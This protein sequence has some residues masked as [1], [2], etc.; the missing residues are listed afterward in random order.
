MKRVYG[1]RRDTMEAR[2]AL[3]R[4]YRA[5]RFRC[6]QFPAA[7]DL[8]IPSNPAF[9]P[10]DQ[11]QLGACTAFALKRCAWYGLNAVALQQT[12]PAA[13]P[14]PSAL[15]QYYCE[16]QND[17][18]VD[19]DAGSTISQGVN[20]LK[21]RGI[22]P[23]KDWPYNPAQFAVTPPLQA[24]NDAQQFEALAV[25]NIPV[26][27]TAIQDCLFNQRCP[28]AFGSDL[29]A[30]FESEQCAADGLVQMPPAGAT[31]IGGHAETIR[32][33]KTAPDGSLLLQVQNSWG[34]AWGDQG[35][36]WFPWNY[37]LSYFS[38]LWAIVQMK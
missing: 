29:F 31:P 36:A 19:Q 25:E 28:I 37:A 35:C 34:G 1:W 2:L 10:L 21:T 13:P 26:D 16:R 32:G 33:W 30:Q 23:E 8:G 24:F 11:G 3:G 17:G 7:F 15:F 18:D 5:T 22:C 20:V 6:I 14:E 27:A 4:P 38:D 9:S 12:P